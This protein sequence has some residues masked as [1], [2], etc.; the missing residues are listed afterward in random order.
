MSVPLSQAQT[1]FLSAFL[2]AHSHLLPAEHQNLPAIFQNC[3]QGSS[4]PSPSAEFP[5]ASSHLALSKNSASNAETAL[6]EAEINLRLDEN[7]AQLL[8][9]RAYHEQ[10]LARLNIQ[11]LEQGLSTRPSSCAATSGY[12]AGTES[13][14]DNVPDLPPSSDAYGPDSEH[15]S[16][17]DWYFDSTESDF[18]LVDG[19]NV[20]GVLKELTEAEDFSAEVDAWLEKQVVDGLDESVSEGQFSSVD[21][22]SASTT[23]R[24]RAFSRV[25]QG[26]DP[27]VHAGENPTQN[28][29]GS[30]GGNGGD[31]C[32]R[33]GQKVKKVR[34]TQ[35]QASKTPASH[36][37]QVQNAVTS[38]LLD[39]LGGETSVD[40]PEC[41]LQMENLRAA[42]K[43][44]PWKERKSLQRNTLINLSHRLLRAE[45]LD[46]GLVF[47]RMINELMFTAKINRFC[48][49][50]GES[51]RAGLG[52]VF[53]GLTSQGFSFHSLMSWYSAGSKWARLAAAGTLY[54]L[55]VIAMKPGLSIK[56]RSKRVNATAVIA[57][58]N[59]F[60]FPSLEVHKDFIQHNMLPLILQLVD[61]IPLE[62]PTLFESMVRKYFNIPQCLSKFLLIISSDN[63][64][65]LHSGM[66]QLAIHR[67]QELWQPLI[68]LELS[69]SSQ[70]SFSVHHMTTAYLTGSS[71]VGEDMIPFPESDSEDERIA[72]SDN[73]LEPSLPAFVG[74]V[75]Q[76]D[77]GD[78]G[79]LA[80]I[81]S[82]F[83]YTKAAAGKVPYP[84]RSKRQQWTEKER[85]LVSLGQ[86]ANS[87]DDL[88]RGMRER[89]YD[90][91]AKKPGRYKPRQKWLQVSNSVIHGREI[92][93]IDA[94]GDL[95]FYTNGTASD[96][97]RARIL[98]ALKAF[99]NLKPA[100]LELTSRNP[101][102]PIQKFPTFHFSYWGRYGQ[103][104]DG[105]KT[106]TWQFSVRPSN[107]IQKFPEEYESLC[108]ILG[109]TL[110]EIV[111]TALKRFPEEL[112]Y[113][114]ANVDIFPI[115]DTSPVKPFTSFVL[116]INV[117]TIA[118]R[119]RGDNFLCIVLD[120]GEHSGGELCLQEAKISLE[121]CHGDW[122]AFSSKRYTHFNMRYDGTR[123]SLVIHSDSSGESYQRDG[124][125]W[126]GN[127]YHL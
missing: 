11:L 114:H 26:S 40:S 66:L 121:L 19:T 59:E 112:K 47:T 42:I 82:T 102:M 101:S 99:F 117:E 74:N 44:A 37:P 71:E 18:T 15:D 111:N 94:D 85:T 35:W 86:K 100:G 80:V 109:T 67:M 97:S 38:L 116:N 60:R 104:S 13:E 12:G 89:F 105:R 68:D 45:A 5:G 88:G 8:H 84:E 41:N 1:K 2:A 103:S 73:I 79:P 43:V 93:I 115:N 61:T 90:A 50:A 122:V 124:H 30:L 69:L 77:D 21:L 78:L 113:L 118:H 7:T 36:P 95:I 24:K 48:A 57:L 3:S 27:D 107:D 110:S 125:G 32:T 33:N 64:L 127:E 51:Q 34:A 25:D 83:S 63:Y 22:A 23:G 98:T 62:I 53:K 126:N 55:M 65:L 70:P 20:N 108:N 75:D 17:E 49:K 119:D 28:M 54:L 92:K 87:L 29:L 81:Q 120:L 31:D 96:S 9:D 39:F 56:L 91:S 6:E 10:E 52:N 14:Y 72:A 16:D 76:K 46:V 58:C 106:N 123:C 4:D